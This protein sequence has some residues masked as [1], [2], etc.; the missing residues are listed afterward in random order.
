LLVYG[1]NEPH[2]VNPKKN[3]VSPTV[4]GIMTRPFFNH[5]LTVVL[6]LLSVLSFFI[7]SL[8]VF[9][10]SFVQNK[11]NPDNTPPNKISSQTATEKK[12]TALAG[13]TFNPIARKEDLL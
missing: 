4:L 12:P 2:H 9:F 8:A 1:V 5:S 6:A 7:L 13:F 10:R 11:L 3:Q